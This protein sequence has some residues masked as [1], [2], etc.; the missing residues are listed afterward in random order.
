MAAEDARRT[1]YREWSR[2][3]GTKTRSGNFENGEQTGEWTT[4]DGQGE[5]YKVTRTKPKPAKPG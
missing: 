4:C 1:G 2:K 5:V 3:D